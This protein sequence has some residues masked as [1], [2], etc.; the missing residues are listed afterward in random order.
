M[1]LLAVQDTGQRAKR[2]QDWLAFEPC[3][4]HLCWKNQAEG[5]ENQVKLVPGNQEC[6]ID[7]TESLSGGSGAGRI[8]L[9]PGSPRKS[10]RSHDDLKTAS[11]EIPD[12]DSVSDSNMAPRV[13]RWPRSC[14]PTHRGGG[15]AVLPEQPRMQKSLLFEMHQDSNFQ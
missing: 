4:E 5:S 15:R 1:P 6:E 9:I 3:S 11:P 8:G 14:S 2:H 7:R 13:E 12:R 10:C